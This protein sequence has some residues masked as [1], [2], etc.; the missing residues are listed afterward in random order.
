M[1][2][3]Y[4]AFAAASALLLTA[5]AK[6]DEQQAPKGHVVTLSASIEEDEETKA[7]I[8]DD[9]SF[10][11]RAYDKISVWTSD[12]KLTDFTIK[13]GVNTATATFEAALDD[14]VYVAGPAIYPARNGHSYNS[15]SNTITY[16]QPVKYDL[17]V[18][19]TKSQMA[20][21]YDE[22]TKNFVFKH[23]GG[24]IRYTIYNP[25]SEAKRVRLANSNISGKYSVNMNA[26]V[27]QISR[28]A[29]STPYNRLDIGFPTSD[30]S[31]AVGNCLVFDFPVPADTYVNLKF[32]LAVDNNTVLDAYDKTISSLALE[33]RQMVKMPAVI[34]NF[35]KFKY[36]DNGNLYT[37]SFNRYDPSVGDP[38]VGD[39]TPGPSPAYAEDGADYTLVD[40]PAK[41]ITSSSTKVLRVNATKGGA[42][43]GYFLLR[44]RTGEGAEYA[45]DFRE[46]SKAFMLKMRYANPEDE[47]I[48]YPQVRCRGGKKDGEDTSHT[49]RL[50]D[51]INGKEFSP[52]TSE[53]WAELI[54]E[55]D[56][57]ILQWD[58]NCENSFRI[59]ITPFL[60]F[61]GDNQTSENDRVMYFDDFGYLK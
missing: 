18:G 4:F 13:D 11:W 8:G 33:R 35:R 44:T 12:G 34:F 22:E 7:I 20:A 55:N 37:A 16:D 43:S 10:K 57:N 50:P 6:T 38:S 46:D 61:S 2:L 30:Y 9:G 48:Y 5:C 1:K 53:K 39:P 40:N 32:Q 47:S 14:G 23:L 52:K 21:K 15:E 45:S 51:R 42:K 25:P 41:S 19:E 17:N 29:V 58:C 56:W 27:P 54:N 59:E 28:E 24:L 3:I 60:N 49:R 26:D 36:K 31:Y